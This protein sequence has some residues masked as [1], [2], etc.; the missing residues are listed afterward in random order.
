MSRDEL[1][2]RRKGEEGGTCESIIPGDVSQS[3]APLVNHGCL[4][5]TRRRE[6]GLRERERFFLLTHPW[7]RRVQSHSSHCFLTMWLGEM[8]A[9]F[10]ATSELRTKEKKSMRGRT[11]RQQ[12][13]LAQNLVA[14]LDAV[15]H[16]AHEKENAST[17]RDTHRVGILQGRAVD[18][19]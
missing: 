16:I 2:E 9:S 15:I 3:F 6:E 4:P 12:Q 5:C 19:M 14:Q 13:T 11:D 10:G 1:S 17:S 18:D 8:A 7:H